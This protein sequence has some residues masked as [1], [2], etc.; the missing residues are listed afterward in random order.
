[1]PTLP[2][3]LPFPPEKKNCT[4]NL[5]AHLKMQLFFF[6]FFS[7]PWQLFFFFDYLECVSLSLFLPNTA[8]GIYELNV[9]Q[10]INFSFCFFPDN[11][12]HLF[13]PWNNFVETQSKPSFFKF[14][15]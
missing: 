2:I 10:P 6:F 1:V 5:P 12:S 9:R 8:D 7:P 3:A 13:L 4:R 14:L 15:V 11:L